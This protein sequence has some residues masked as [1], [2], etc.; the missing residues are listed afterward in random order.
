MCMDVLYVYYTV[1]TQPVVVVAVY[2]VYCVL[3]PQCHLMCILFDV[4]GV[5]SVHCAAGSI[6]SPLGKDRVPLQKG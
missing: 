5:I 2:R 3:W 1:S 4:Y 6:P